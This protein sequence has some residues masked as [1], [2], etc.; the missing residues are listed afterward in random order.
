MC[1]HSIVS[2]DTMSHGLC[3]ADGLTWEYIDKDESN[4]LFYEIFDRRAYLNHGINLKS[5]D[6]IV[7]LGSNIGLFPLFLS[8]IASFQP[9]KIVAVE[10]MPPVI[11]VLQRNVVDRL[12]T[13]MT[14]RQQTNH[15]IEQQ[16]MPYFEVVNSRKQKR[17]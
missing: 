11:D 14:L 5:G 1:L 16:G 7:D 13:D 12:M 15:C 2:K 10:P 17:A 4:F 6:T 9:I 3:M 8:T